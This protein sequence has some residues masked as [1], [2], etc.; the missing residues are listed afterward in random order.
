MCRIGSLSFLAWSFGL[1]P[2][3][4]A[5]TVGNQIAACAALSGTGR[6]NMAGKPF[7]QRGNGERLQKNVRTSDVSLVVS[8]GWSLKQMLKVEM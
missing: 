7:F 4:N 1:H 6:L 5:L 2:S 8:F 3:V